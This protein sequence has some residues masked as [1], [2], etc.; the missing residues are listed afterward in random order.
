MFYIHRKINNMNTDQ[1]QLWIFE[2][3]SLIVAFSTQT[4]IDANLTRQK[5]YQRQIFKNPLLS[6]IAFFIA[7]SVFFSSFNVNVEVC[8]ILEKNI[9]LMLFREN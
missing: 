1:R 9:T 4:Q 8:Q 2:G 5:F 3:L 7:L 6:L